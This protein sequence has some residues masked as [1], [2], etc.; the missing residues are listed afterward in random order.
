[1]PLPVKLHVHHCTISAGIQMWAI[2]P[3]CA[4][5]LPPICE[6]WLNKNKPVP[7]QKCTQSFPDRQWLALAGRPKEYF[8]NSWS[9]CMPRWS[10]C[11]MVWI[12]ALGHGLKAWCSPL[13]PWMWRALAQRLVGSHVAHN[14]FL[15]PSHPAQTTRK[16]NLPDWTDS[17]FA[18]NLLRRASRSALS[19]SLAWGFAGPQRKTS[20]PFGVS[21]VMKFQHKKKEKNSATESWR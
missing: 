17:L 20:F 1:M 16:Q 15:A 10:T 8:P 9:E 3:R 11:L 2:R 14:P 4:I 6:T 12:H 18:L 5:M 13:A 21:Y 7:S 19:P